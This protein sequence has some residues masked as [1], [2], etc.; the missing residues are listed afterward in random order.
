M[1]REDRENT[2]RINNSVSFV[3]E[4]TD[5]LDAVI[6]IIDDDIKNKNLPTL[7]CLLK[8]TQHLLLRLKL[9]QLKM[10]LLH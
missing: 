8:L 6:D 9:K 5:S 1:E 7:M 3:P 2:C 4:T 10:N